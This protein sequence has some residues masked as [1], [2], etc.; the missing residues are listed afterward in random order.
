MGIFNEFNK[1]EKPVFTGS[2][3]GFGSGGGGGG[4]AGT[5]KIQGTGGTI[6]TDTAGD[7]IIHYITNPAHNFTADAT[8]SDARIV[9]VGGGAAGGAEHGGGGGAGKVVYTASD[10][11]IQ[12]GTHP[13]S[14]GAGASFNG[15][16]GPGNDGQKSR[17]GDG[18]TTTFTVNSTPIQAIGGG[19]GGTYNNN[20]DGKAGGSS[21]GGGAPNGGGGAVTANP[22]IPGDF[23]AVGYSGGGGSDNNPAQLAGGGGGGGGGAG[24]NGGGSA[25]G[26]GGAGFTLP[27]F[28]PDVGVAGKVAGGGGGAGYQEANSPNSPNA[29][30]GAN[31][32][33]VEG[34]AGRGG[35]GPEDG[36]LSMNPFFGNGPG[37]GE[38]ATAGTGS[39][40]GG[41]RNNTPGGGGAGGSGCVII[42]YGPSL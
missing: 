33:T 37:G 15:P 3:F 12:A 39:G 41:S 19:G 26:D 11:T 24:E 16:S 35:F 30:A 20:K 9:V 42:S 1:K 38:N 2:R 7:R 13:I 18:S 22:P 25:G 14:L 40:G 32:P 23:T 36:G 5:L 34:G 27:W 21:G 8:I 10:Y 28:T 4:P 17:G 6:I 29:L 31:V